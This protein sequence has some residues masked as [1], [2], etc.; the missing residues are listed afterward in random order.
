MKYYLDR[1]KQVIFFMAVPI[2]AP[3]RAK[4]F[5]GWQGDL[6][7]GALKYQMLLRIELDGNKVVR[8]YELLKG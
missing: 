5:K 4:C 3:I 8:Q 1:V 6:L 2:R 7:V